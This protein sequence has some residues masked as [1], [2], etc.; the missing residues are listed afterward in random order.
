MTVIKITNPYFDKT[1]KVV[2]KKDNV[3]YSISN[4]RRGNEEF[5]FLHDIETGDVITISPR[6]CASV[7]IQA[8]SEDI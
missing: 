7:E 3:E 6:C 4:I 5:L 8:E 1:Y 2:E